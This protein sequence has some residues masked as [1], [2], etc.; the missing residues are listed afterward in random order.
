MTTIDIYKVRLVDSNGDPLIVD[1]QGLATALKQDTQIALLAKGLQTRA[2]SF[3]IVQAS[4]AIAAN[5]PQLQG[6][7]VALS[8]S[9]V[10]INTDILAAVDVSAYR[11]LTLQLT[12]FGSATIQVQVSLDAGV[13]YVALNGFNINSLAVASNLT[14]NGIY[15]FALPQ[16]ALLRIR[17]T[18]WASGTILGFIGLSAIPYSLQTYA[19]LF[20]SNG[21]TITA[22]TPST[23]AIAT[24]T[25]GIAV[26]G[27]NVLY[28]ALANNWERMRV[29]NI[30]KQIATVAIGAIA[31]VWTPTAGKKFNLMG[32]NISVSAAVSVLFEDNAA[33]A[34][35]YQTPMLEANKPYFFT[36]GGTHSN[37]ILSALANNVLK[38][39]SSGAANLIGTLFGTEE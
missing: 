31:T 13:T 28:D 24:T 36:V 30:F 21:S 10:A 39:T 23:D 4:D 8:G 15:T 12:G 5:A 38:A 27:H 16:N 20:S 1:D 29:C 6:A 2:N 14:A 26:V 32:G 37:G 9:V 22:A 19:A 35:V 33:A 25:N 7:N 18:A 34:F 17:A 3:S 11:Q